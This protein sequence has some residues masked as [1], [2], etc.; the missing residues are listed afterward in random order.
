MINRQYRKREM[1]STEYRYKCIKCGKDNKFKDPF[2]DDDGPYFHCSSC[3]ERNL[4]KNTKDDSLGLYYKCPHCGGRSRVIDEFCLFRTMS[5]ICSEKRPERAIIQKLSTVNKKRIWLVSDEKFELPRSQNQ[6]ELIRCMSKM[7]S[8]FDDILISIKNPLKQRKLANEEKLLLTVSSFEKEF[9]DHQIKNR[10]KQYKHELPIYDAFFEYFKND[11]IGIISK[12][13]IKV[14]LRDYAEDRAQ[15]AKNGPTISSNTKNKYISYVS[16]FFKWLEEDKDIS[17]DVNP[18]LG[19]KRESFP[20]PDPFFLYPDEFKAFIEYTNIFNRKNARLKAQAYFL[21]LCH[22]GARTQCGRNLK[23]EDVNFKAGTV[24]LCSKGTTVRHVKMTSVLKQKLGE[25]LEYKNLKYGDYV[26]SD[27]PKNIFYEIKKTL[28][29]E[30]DKLNIESR[31]EAKNRVKQF[32]PHKFRHSF[33]TWS[34]FINGFNLVNVQAD[35]GHSSSFITDIY[36]HASNDELTRQI[37][38]YGNPFEM[39]L[40]LR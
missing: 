40:E 2:Y 33:A 8:Y 1:A 21:L 10:E 20:D 3:K 14:F 23:V 13:D 9:R 35:L 18:A 11:E 7:I 25:Y 15:F 12:S 34:Y 38:E 6:K 22:A 17:L 27:F 19:I 26:F 5:S 29:E 28:S 30:A 16:C 24:K 37:K 31:L 4:I 32:S 39:K 36:T